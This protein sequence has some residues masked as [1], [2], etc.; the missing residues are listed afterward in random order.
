MGRLGPDSRLARSAVNVFG[1]RIS[2]RNSSGQL[3]IG[4]ITVRST[5]S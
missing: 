4:L 5:R 1:Q 2:C 3:L